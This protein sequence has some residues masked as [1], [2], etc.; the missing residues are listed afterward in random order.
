[1][2]N[3]EFR[4]NREAANNYMDKVAQESTY[5]NFH[6]GYTKV[7]HKLH[8]CF[9]LSQYEKL[10]LVDLIAYMSNKHK[11]YPT[12]ENIARNVGCSS[13]SVE[14]HMRALQEKKLVLVGQ[15]RKNNEYYLP[16]NFYR[17]PYF[18]MSEKTHEFVD[19]L[20]VNER[21]LTN[22]IQGIVDGEEYEGF[23]KEL[24]FL[25]KRR[26]PIMKNEEAIHL[27]NYAQFLQKEFKKRFPSI[28]IVS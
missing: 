13:K 7:P 5:T 9:G 14:R 2:N 25:N 23:I 3:N 15:S 22:W 10:I 17:H 4:Y 26:L 19:G 16:E 6:N 18:L 28:Q 11:C 21:E 12:I 1:M 24:E 20:V 27:T 8:R